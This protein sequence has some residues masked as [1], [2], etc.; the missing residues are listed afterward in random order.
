MRV[1]FQFSN[2]NNNHFHLIFILL[3]EDHSIT[4]N[5]TQITLNGAGKILGNTRNNSPVATLNAGVYGLHMATFAQPLLRF[6][7]S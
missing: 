2:I 1:Y 3:L 7:L 5:Q 4:L 6:A